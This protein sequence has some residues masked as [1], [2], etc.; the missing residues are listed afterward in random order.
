VI[1]EA[2]TGLPAA[3]QAAL[4][5]GL[6][7]LENLAEELRA[8]VRRD[9]AGLRDAPPPGLPAPDPQCASFPATQPG[10]GDRAGDHRDRWR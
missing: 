9:G 10:G 1:T 4:V 2:V 3:Q 7:A 8:T 6:P 5:A